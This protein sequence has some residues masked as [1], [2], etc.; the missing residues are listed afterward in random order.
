M[1]MNHDQTFCLRTGLESSALNESEFGVRVFSFLAATYHQV[2]AAGRCG[3][4]YDTLDLHYALNITA[5][6]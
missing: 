6:K 1:P 5:M 4:L 2:W 3:I